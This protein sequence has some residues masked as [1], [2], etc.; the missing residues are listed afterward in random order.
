MKGMGRVLPGS[1]AAA[2]PSPRTLRQA[3]LQVVVDQ[4]L[5]PAPHLLPLLAAG[6]VQVISTAGG[7]GGQGAASGSGSRQV[8]HL[9]AVAAGRVHTPAGRGS[10]KGSHACGQCFVYSGLHALASRLRWILRGNIGGGGAE[11]SSTRQFVWNLWTVSWI[12]KWNK[13]RHLTLDI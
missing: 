4:V 6:R 10:R 5:A 8:T 2:P 7:Y 9:R 13:S 3:P 11:V 1:Q 12:F